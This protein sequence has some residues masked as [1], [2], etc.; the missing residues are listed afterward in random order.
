MNADFYMDFIRI[1]PCN[2]WL[3]SGDSVALLVFLPRSTRTRFVAPDFRLVSHNS[4]NFAVFFT[5]GSRTL[6][7]SSESQRARTRRHP[8]SLL[9]PLRVLFSHDLQIEQRSNGAGVDAVEHLLEQVETLLFVLNQRIL[10][11]VTDQSDSLFQVIERQ[12]VVLPLRVDD[13]QHQDA[14]VGAHRFRTNLLLFSFVLDLETFPNRVDHF[15]CG[16]VWNVEPLTIGVE[17]VDGL[18]LRLIVL[19]VPVVLRHIRIQVLPGQV[20]QQIISNTGRRR[21][22][23]QVIAL[24]RFFHQLTTQAIN[25]LTLLVHHVVVFKQVFTSFEVS[26]FD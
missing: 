22:A 18:Y 8:S 12:Q 5:R 26:P 20:R 1:H 10:L 15:L 6:I 7:W 3:L 25:R 23:E 17:I 19:D 9:Q 16:H 2:L 21:I 14:L 4:F 13:I 24:I 11:A